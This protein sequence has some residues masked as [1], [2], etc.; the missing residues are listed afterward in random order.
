MRTGIELMIAMVA[1]NGLTV[2]SQC[3]D[4]PEFIGYSVLVLA[5]YFSCDSLLEGG[6]IALTEVQRGENPFVEQN[7]RC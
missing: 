2:S 5:S 6:H 1:H 3:L 7:N 4:F